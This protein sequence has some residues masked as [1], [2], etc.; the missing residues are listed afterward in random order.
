MQYFIIIQNNI[1]T[2]YHL[3]IQQSGKTKKAIPILAQ[4]KVPYPR[5]ELLMQSQNC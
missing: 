4:T 2:L 3:I 5:R 1:I